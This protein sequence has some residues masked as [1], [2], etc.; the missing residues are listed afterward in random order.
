MSHGEE[1]IPQNDAE[2]P[3]DYLSDEATGRHLWNNPEPTFELSVIEDST[4]ILSGFWYCPVGRSESPG[5][6]Y[7]NNLEQDMR[8]D[9]D[10]DGES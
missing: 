8:A 7:D 1:A 5:Q 10:S 4:R 9:N 3:E 2:T 6:H